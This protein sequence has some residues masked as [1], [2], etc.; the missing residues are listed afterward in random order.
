MYKLYATITAQHLAANDL[1]YAVNGAWPAG[2]AVCAA[3]LFLAGL[4]SVV[5]ESMTVA[6]DVLLRQH[7]GEE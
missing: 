3:I 4:A 1:V 7:R 2:F 5:V 6:P